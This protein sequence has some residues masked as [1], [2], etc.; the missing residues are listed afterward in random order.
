MWRTRFKAGISLKLTGFL[1]AISVAPLMI[2]LVVSYAT[3]RQTIVEVAT[4]HSMQLLGNQLDYLQLQMDQI[5]GLATNL[6]SAEEINKAFAAAAAGSEVQ[7]TYDTLATNARVGYLLNGYSSLK[8]LVSIDLVTKSGKQYHVGDTLTV[9]NKTAVLR[10]RLM[11]RTLAL[12]GQ[13]IW[14]GVEDNL[15]A[16][17]VQRKVVMASRSIDRPDASGLKTEPIGMLLI[18]YSTAFL[19]EHFSTIDMGAGAQLLVVDARQRLLFHPNKA[20]IG[21]AITSGLGQNLRGLAGS[22]AMRIDDHDML[23]SYVKIPDKQWYVIGIV[24]QTTLTAPMVNIERVVAAVVLTSLLLIAAFIRRYSQQVVAP[25]RNISDGLRQFEANRLAPRWRLPQP[26]ALDE[27]GELVT[28]FNSFLDTME[29]RAQTETALRIAAIAFESQEGMV[30]TDAQGMI[31]QVNR[32]FVEMTGYTA[33]EAIGQSMQLLESGLHDAAFST[34]MQECIQRS[35]AW[36]GEVWSRRKN[37]EVYPQWL[38]MTEVKRD[39]GE[40]THY[41]GAMND[42][43]LRKKAD[44]EIWNL[45]FFDPLTRLP[46][47][48][49]LLDRLAQALTASA[50][51]RRCGALLFIDLDNF[52]AIN[53]TLGHDKGDQLLQQTAL[54]LSACVRKGD[55]V[56]RLGG[57]EFVVMLGD[58]SEDQHEAAA[59]I[60]IVGSN[61][62]ATLNQAYSLGGHEV[63]S[64]PSIGMT[65]F[66]EGKDSVDELLRRADLAMYQGKAS[67]RNRMVFF[68]PTMQT[69]VSKRAE[70]DM[71][72]RTALREDQFILFYQPQVDGKGQLIGAE[73]LV[74]WQHPQRGLVGPAEF[75]PAAEE[76]GL[77]LPLGRWVLETACKQ[78]VV[79]GE[80]PETALLS[81]SVNVSACEFRQTDFVAQEL[82]IIDRTGVD[83]TR[84]KLELTE[85]LLVIDQEDVI[86]KMLALKAQGVAFSLDDFGTGFSSLSYLRRMPLGQLKIDQSF[87]NDVLTDANDAAIA[88]SII[89]LAHS[90]GLLAIAEGVETEQ[91]FAFLASQGCDAFQGYWFGRPGPVAALEPSIRAAY[92]MQ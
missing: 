40:I 34:A 66:S 39:D 10:D 22:V 77:I 36:T 51:H 75:I 2:Y 59:Q 49:L 65:S 15:S 62:L 46:N 87:V 56:A 20:L 57:D 14:H 13:M 28:W 17:A 58:L 89:T 16:A 64:T 23:M 70:L 26:K 67:G 48:R 81:L 92:E 37:G 61:I 29:A 82:A 79:W 35:G 78:L 5:D 91:Q 73:A 54:R 21:Q 69:A 24:P 80:R 63:H 86:A 3:T 9:D 83:A 52:K 19:Y 8:G 6:G 4:R 71:D 47:R 38:S 50:R 33:V 76:S 11:Q 31:L 85:S 32:A 55:T 90:L 84:L 68:D 60:E 30:V 7:S 53:D 41:V 1:L 88:R 74:R 43:T 18:S 42:I 45:A 44:E 12:P 27:I 72:L 25:I